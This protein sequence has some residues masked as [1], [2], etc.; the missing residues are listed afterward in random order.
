MEKKSNKLFIITRI[1]IILFIISVCFFIYSTLNVKNIDSMKDEHKK[2]SSELES[3]NNEIIKIKKEYD[4]EK[5][6]LE[7]LELIFISKYGYDIKE[8]KDKEVEKSLDILK[9]E[10][11]SIETQI[12][13]DI[14]LFSDYYSGNY[15]NSEEFDRTANMFLDLTSMGSVEELDVDLYS[16]IELDKFINIAKSEG[17]IGYLTNLNKNSNKNNVI[18]FSTAFY[19]DSLNR[20]K[21]KG[22]LK[23]KE[24][25][26]LN[27]NINILYEVFKLAEDSGLSTGELSSNRLLKLKN[28]INEFSKKYY[29]NIGIIQVLRSKGDKI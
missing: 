2:L 1:S 18:L 24:I 21:E 10:N 9:N 25:S 8:K 3:I 15:Y 26:E 11:K 5:N 27:E 7:D 29:E 14:E 20:L 28:N 23:E 16:Q 13:T 6:N 12:K 17:T 4:F 19:S 22:E